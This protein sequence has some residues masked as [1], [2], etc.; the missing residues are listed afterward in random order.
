MKRLT[1][2][3]PR[4]C[5]LLEN[6]RDAKSQSVGRMRRAALL[7]LF[8]RV[9]VLG[10]CL[11]ICGAGT[12]ADGVV[13][14]IDA[15]QHVTASYGE[16]AGKIRVRWEPVGEATTY[17][18]ERSTSRRG[19]FALVGDV[20]AGPFD[21]AGVDCR[22]YWY[23][24]SAC[25][26]SCCSTPSVVVRGRQGVPG[27]P[28]AAATDGVFTDR[29]QVSWGEVE[30][31]STFD[32]YRATTERGRYRLLGST[33]GLFYD[34]YSAQACMKVW[35]KVR[36]RGACG[37]GQ[38][39]S[40]AWGRRGSVP[41]PDGVVATKGVPTDR[42]RVTW[43]RV[44]QASTYVIYRSETEGGSYTKVG[45]TAATS[46]DDLAVT[47]CQTYWYRVQCCTAS[48]GCSALSIPSQESHGWPGSSL[49][50][51][52]GVVASDGT[53][54]SG[55]RV[56]WSPVRLA[57]T[58]K[59]ERAT[60]LGG[61][62]EVIDVVAGVSYDDLQ[63]PPGEPRCYRVRAAC[64]TGE[65]EPSAADCGTRGAPP[66]SPTGVD[67]SDLA[68]CGKIRVSWTGVEGATSY[69]VLFSSTRE[70]PYVDIDGGEVQGVTTYDDSR[71]VGGWYRVVACGPCGESVPSGEDSGYPRTV[72]CENTWSDDM[73]S[74]EAWTTT[75]L[76]HYTELNGEGDVDPKDSHS[77]SHA[78]W[79]GNPATGTYGLQS[80]VMS[81]LSRW[82][83]GVLGTKSSGGVSGTA[84]SPTI[85]VVPGAAV[86]LS[87]WYWREV[88][89]YD[90]RFDRTSVRVRFESGTWTTVW[91]RDSSTPSEKEWTT[92]DGPI[93]LPVPGGASW[94]QVQFVFN[95]VDGANN[96]YRGW[97][98]DDVSVFTATTP[99]EAARA[100]ALGAE[101]L[102]FVCKPNPVRDVHTAV[103]SVEGVT[104]DAV[105]V[106]IYDLSGVAVFSWESPGAEVVWHT[107][108][109]AGQYLANGVYLYR[110]WARIAGAWVPCD[111]AGKV[112]I[113]R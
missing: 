38:L 93:S 103:F 7:R 87:F 82:A 8:I 65:S 73:E 98:I 16:F 14:E 6:P 9:V 94:M 39:S 5:R 74:A 41:A 55:I 43:N 69:K 31:A 90:G 13:C 42:V 113:L 107:E 35:Y 58:Y 99:P 78:L 83:S 62:Y 10:T 29:V 26:A 54:C 34:D 21:D 50:P 95:S 18:V 68:F 71:R 96:G 28:T 91:E 19:P 36:A 47:A 64:G 61:A 46:F 79:F 25:G 12:A 89:L 20:A 15:P 80:G 23:R 53:L 24:V 27:K 75:G 33:G 48:C 72:G 100:Q 111:E 109:S 81:T 70:G 49:T 102:R 22:T 105:R 45:G 3:R 57:S 106:E 60:S 2:A 1:G 104:V 66:A 52:I 17:R 97:F 67:A 32:V 76:W 40:P 84:T 56:T 44:A 101:G 92:P 88:E 37:L 86:E 77:A 112:V 110:M 11:L 30:G 63:A 4:H 85:N 59:I 51:P 108:D